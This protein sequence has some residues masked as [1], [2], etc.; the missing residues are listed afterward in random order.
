MGLMNIE[1]ER[2]SLSKRTIIKLC[3]QQTVTI[4]Y[5]ENFR[6]VYPH[7]Y[8]RNHAQT[9]VILDFINDAGESLVKLRM[10]NGSETLVERCY[11][12]EARA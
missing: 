6:R 7:L 2:R 1:A 8:A 10:F 5:T 4:D 11:I 12:L 3:R 9:G